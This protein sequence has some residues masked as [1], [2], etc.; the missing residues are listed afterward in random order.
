MVQCGHID[1]KSL[2]DMYYHNKRQRL[3]GHLSTRTHNPI[4]CKVLKHVVLSPK[5][6]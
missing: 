6:R 3:A 5:Y 1:V 4:F 2:E